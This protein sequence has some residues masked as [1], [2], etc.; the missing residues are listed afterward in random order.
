MQASFSWVRAHPYSLGLPSLTDAGFPL[1]DAWLRRI[2]SR[3]GSARAIE[4]DMISR[5]KGERGWQ[6]KVREKARWVWEEEEGHE[7]KKDEL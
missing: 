5:L 4:G 1:T 7:R 2:E 6:D 3:A